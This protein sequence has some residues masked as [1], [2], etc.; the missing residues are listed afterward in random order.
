MLALELT[1]DEARMI[2][3]YQF[4]TAKPM[5]IAPNIGKPTLL[6]HRRLP[7]SPA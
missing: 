5:L 6:I 3:G 2:R 1:E 7:I 4:L